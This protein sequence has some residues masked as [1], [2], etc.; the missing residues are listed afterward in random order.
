MRPGPRFLERAPREGV[1]CAETI[2]LLRA[3]ATD[4]PKQADTPADAPA[5]T[6]ADTPKEERR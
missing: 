2:G 6:P 4:T 1:R 5:D 3:G